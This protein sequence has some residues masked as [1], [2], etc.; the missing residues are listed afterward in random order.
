MTSISTSLD[1]ERK[2]RESE[3]KDIY[4]KL[5][6]IKT[7]QDEQVKLNIQEEVA[8]VVQVEVAKVMN[9]KPANTTAHNDDDDITDR[10]KQVIVSGFDENTDATVI[11]ATIEDFLKVDTRRAKVVN[12]D[13]FS[14]PSQIGVITFQ[15]VA[16]KIGLFKKIRGQE[17]TLPNDKVMTFDNNETF[18][19]RVCNKPLGQIKFQMNRKLGHSLNNIRIDRKQAVVKL[20]RKVVA[21][22]CE[23]GGTIYQEEA[24]SVENDVNEYM[25]GWL[26]KKGVEV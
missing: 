3:V 20:N 5:E 16:S 26:A 21:E 2:T 8:K 17:V 11:I 4:A 18:E 24:K 14:D 12:I 25:K 1:T 6:N 15:S 19:V 9:N 10:A 7:N 13:T 22:F 23:N